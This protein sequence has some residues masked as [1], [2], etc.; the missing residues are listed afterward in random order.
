MPSLPTCTPRARCH[1]ARKPDTLY[2]HHVYIYIYIVQL[3]FYCFIILSLKKKYR[4]IVVEILFY[5]CVFYR[6][7]KLI[8]D[9]NYIYGWNA[10]PLKLLILFPLCTYFTSNFV[11]SYLANIS[12]HKTPRKVHKHSNFP[13]KVLS[14]RCLIMRTGVQ[15]MQYP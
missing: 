11:I 1:L 10:F 12:K 5:H 7:S 13:Y 14:P 15:L 3:S 6:Y 9:F 4:F 8:N 2:M